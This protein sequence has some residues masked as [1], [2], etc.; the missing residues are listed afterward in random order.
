MGC[1]G[2]KPVPAPLTKP[3]SQPLEPVH[4]APKAEPHAEHQHS[5]KEKV[6]KP[7]VTRD[8]SPPPKVVKPPTPE[9]QQFEC[10]K[11]H[12]LKW[13]SDLPFYYYHKSKLWVIS[14]SV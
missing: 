1:C 4:Q 13:H 14:F 2:S 8:P 12:E 11:G 7:E 10:G 5:H 6:P 9:P 3:P